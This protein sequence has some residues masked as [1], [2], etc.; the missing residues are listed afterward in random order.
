[1]A[2]AGLNIH[3]TPTE[4]RFYGRADRVTRFL[5]KR[6]L[7]S[8]IEIAGISFP[9]LPSVEFEDDG[10]VLKRFRVSMWL[11]ESS[12]LGRALDFFFWYMQVASHYAFRRVVCVNA[13]TLSVLPLCWVI[14]ILKRC[15]LIYEPH[16]LET[17]TR[18]TQGLIKPLLRLCERLFIGRAARI[19]TVNG[20]IAEW[21][22]NTYRLRD[23]A[24]VRNLPRRTIAE[25]LPGNYYASLFGFPESDLVFLYQGIISEGRGIE[26]LLSTFERL[27]ADRHIV[28]LGFGAWTQR[29]KD[30][31]SR[32][33]N[34]HYHPPVSSDQLLR[35]PAC[36]DVGVLLYENTSL[37]N[38]YSYSNKYCEYLTSGTPVLFSEFLWL[39]GEAEKYDCGWPAPLSADALAQYIATI[40]KTAIRAKQQGAR[41]WACDNNWSSE[42]RVLDEIYSSLFGQ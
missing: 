31:A 15:T 13:H 33:S 9:G 24:V 6:G 22:R 30:A 21:Y 25:P 38:Y 29:I 26:L 20:G 37:N 32:N 1:M 42:E 16:E 18:M 17:E 11:R 34:V 2:R 7:F 36:A 35:Y 39:R 23:V 41:N 27:P 8:N 40:D 10:R 12:R 19:I 14:A 3:I 4:L 5:M 28:F